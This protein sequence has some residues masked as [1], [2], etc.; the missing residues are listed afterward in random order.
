[1]LGFISHGESVFLNRICFPYKILEQIPVRYPQFDFL[2]SGDRRLAPLT[3]LNGVSSACGY[4]RA[5]RLAPNMYVGPF[6]GLPLQESGPQLLSA[7]N[8]GGGGEA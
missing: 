3:Q 1:M 6:E 4:S 2:S 8:G 7:G 5:I